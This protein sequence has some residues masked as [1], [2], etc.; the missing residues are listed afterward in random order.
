MCADDVV[1]SGAEPLAFLDYV[2]V[3]RLDPD[4][5]AEL[6][7][8]VADGLPAGGLRAGR[9]RDR[10]APGPDGGRRVRPRGVL[11][12]HRGARPPPRRDGGPRPATR[13][14]A[15]PRPGCTPTAT[16]WS[17]RSSPSTSSSCA[18]RT[19][20]SCAGRWA[21][22]QAS[23]CSRRSRSHAMATLGEVL[24][25]PT[26]IYA[27]DVL[28][29]RAALVA[30]GLRPARRSP[31]SRAAG[32]RQ[33]AARAARR[34][35]ARGSTRRRWPMPSVMRLLGA[36]GGDRGRR[37]ARDVQRRPRAWSLVV[38]AARSPARSRARPARGIA[39]CRL[40]RGRGR[41]RRDAR[42][43]PVR[44]GATA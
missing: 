32:C 3:G 38:P 25:T 15:S 11:H 28:A 41:R 43:A 40:A 27:R 8:G 14:S 21:T 7:G 37:A 17:G 30:A 6:V 4:S 22:R 12:R 10:R 19:R 35:S 34:A 26:R 13:S 18:R 16:R 44:G 5:V 24:L 42:G 1:C 39:A 2:A 36:L 23:R 29:I 9:R 33:R 20:R 31:T